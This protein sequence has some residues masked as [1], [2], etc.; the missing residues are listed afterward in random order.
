VNPLDRIFIVS[1]LLLL[2][3]VVKWKN[4]VFLSPSLHQVCREFCLQI[5]STFL[6]FVHYLELSSYDSK[7]SYWLRECLS[8]SFFNC[9][10]QFW[11]YKN[12]LSWLPKEFFFSFLNCR[13]QI[14]KFPYQSKSTNMLN[15]GFSLEMFEFLKK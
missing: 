14:T 5:A 2:I 4:L 8:L 1:F 10:S 11:I 9:W 12:L 3:F 15:T 13:C 7:I 6:L